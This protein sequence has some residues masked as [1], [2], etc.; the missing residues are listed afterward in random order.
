MEKRQSVMS[1]VDMSSIFDC[2]P[3]LTNMDY[4]FVEVLI[5]AVISWVARLVDNITAD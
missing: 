1:Q 2:A 4:H 5:T 3:A